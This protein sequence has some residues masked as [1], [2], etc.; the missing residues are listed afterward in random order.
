MA[1][2]PI[3]GRLLHAL[4]DLSRQPRPAPPACRD[5]ACPHLL[6]WLCSVHVVRL[7]LN[8][9]QR[10]GP[11][12]GSRE[13]LKRRGPLL[14]ALAAVADSASWQP[15]AYPGLPLLA[16]DCGHSSLGGG[17]GEEQVTSEAVAG[18]QGWVPASCVQARCPCAKHLVHR[19]RLH[20]A[21]IRVLLATP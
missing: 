13:F 10:P 7:K 3:S 18:M 20:T 19:C 6:R 1:A 15:A 17:F 5:L 12:L 4:E 14:A 9:K 11:I 8:Q 2:A 16:L 21:A